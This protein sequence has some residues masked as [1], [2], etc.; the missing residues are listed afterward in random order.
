[1]IDNAPIADPATGPADEA[2]RI[3][4]AEPRDLDDL[5]A[6]LSSMVPH[7]SPQ[8]VWELPW[9]WPGY[10]VV[11]D[12]DDR[13]VASAALTDLDEQ[14]LEVR[15]V[16]VHP[17]A[18]G[19]G[20]ATRLLRHLLSDPEAA[21]R[22]VVCITRRPGFFARFGFRETAPVWVPEHRLSAPPSGDDAT[23]ADAGTNEPPAVRVAMSRPPTGV[24]RTGTGPLRPRL[25]A[26]PLPPSAPHARVG[27][28]IG[29]R[30]RTDLRT[31][32]RLP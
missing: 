12:R 4:S 11:R 2:V 22:E 20:L 10:R 32:G 28:G 17:D 14:R 18:R 16:A 24:V 8:T 6:L 3:V 13:V 27:T 31:K 7:S 15:G 21:G 5:M 26:A 9:A 29:A 30:N 19:R 25:V 1:M 23:P